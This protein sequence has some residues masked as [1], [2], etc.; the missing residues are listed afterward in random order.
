MK[1]LS[2]LPCVLLA[3][4]PLAQSARPLLFENSGIRFDDDP[5][6]VAVVDLDGNG[7][8]DLAVAELSPAGLCVRLQLQVG[9][10]TDPEL[11]GAGVGYE[12][13]D[14]ADLDGDGDQD[15]VAVESE[16]AGDLLVLRN[17]GDGTFQVQ[18]LVALGGQA[19][20]VR[21]VDLD[22]DGAVDVLVTLEDTGELLV[23]PGLGDGT[24][25][26]AAR[27]AVVVQ[28]NDLDVGDVDGDGNPDVVLS[29][30]FSANVC[31]LIN[32]DVGFFEETRYFKT[33]S[34]DDVAIA[35]TDLDGLP[36]V[37]VLTNGGIFWNAETLVVA[38]ENLLLDSRL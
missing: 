20:A 19:S 9:F 8:P 15:P 16:A 24:L 28:V 14:A 2:V 30:S 26:V 7:L 3:S 5:R 33:E 37:A 27:H 36:D 4:V 32:A 35:D 18:S 11:Y 34:P 17:D 23:F 31:V 38:L 12:G 13:V 29:A 22:A 25:D 6:G 1:T 10:F 21:A